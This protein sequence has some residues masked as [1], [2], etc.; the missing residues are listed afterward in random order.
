MITCLRDMR[1]TAVSFALL[2]AAC[3]SGATSTGIQEVTCPPDSTLTY[4]NFG[5]AMVSTEC[6]SCH[7]DKSPKL[8]TQESIKAHAADILDTAVYTDA[9]PQDG[10]MS[11]EE[12]QLL[13]EWLA[14]G[15]P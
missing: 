6:M 12:R 9:M 4:A 15:A 10:T 3:T 14:C 5:Q 13:G 1:I 11:I 2:L 7:A 8:A